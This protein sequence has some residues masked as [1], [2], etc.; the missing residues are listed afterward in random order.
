[1]TPLDLK[2]LSTAV[3]E[4]AA[5]F[6][7]KR[8]L[9]PA[10]GPGTK[11][12]PPTYAGAVYAEEK[13]KL[14]GREQPVPCVLLDSVQ[15]QANRM[16]E[17]L[18]QAID[19]GR[20][21]LPLIEVDF[22]GADLL[23][24]IDK[25]TSL[26]APHRIADA[27]LRD[28]EENG[29][30]FPA[31]ESGK[32][33]GAASAANATPLFKLCPTALVFGMWDSTGLKGGLGAKFERAVVSEIVGI[34]YEKGEKNRGVRRDPLEASKAVLVKG[35]R[36]DWKVADAGAAKGTMRP[37]EI[38]HGSVPFDNP[39]GG[40][41]IASAEQTITLS[42]IALRRLRFPVNGTPTPQ[43]DGAARTV[44]A[45]LALCAATLAAENGL[46]LRSRCLLWPDSH[47]G[48]ELLAKPGQ[49]P[50]TFTLDGPGAIKLLNDA[51]AHAATLGL[52]WLDKPITLKPSKQ[53]TE[54]VRKSQEVLA[55]TGGEGED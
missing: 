16:E 23:E 21:K 2:T 41:T 8:T 15:S 22:S 39:N 30:M 5:A 31:S 37:S 51:V 19:S 55:K 26:Q 46:D 6:R 49:P 28:S 32:A 12:F 24:K 14:P 20:M 48:W 7:C 18:Q 3:Q 50:E 43:I 17:A 53:L 38:N 1:M 29:V 10:G 9:Q 40:C 11:V 44:L 52:K 36:L 35:S 47:M 25:I 13:R 42:L 45:A 54:L 33:L 4:N 27:I 34:D